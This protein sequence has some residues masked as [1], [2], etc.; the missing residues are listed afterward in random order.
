MLADR[1]DRADR[2]A[3]E[4][5]MMEQVESIIFVFEV[6]SDCGSSGGCRLVTWVE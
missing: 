1:A 3:L 2:K 5:A 6:G 4:Q